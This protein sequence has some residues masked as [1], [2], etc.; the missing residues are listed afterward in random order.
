MW[1]RSSSSSGTVSLQGLLN[2][3][4][5]AALCDAALRELPS[6]FHVTQVW[7][8]LPEMRRMRPDQADQPIAK[9]EGCFLTYRALNGSRAK[10]KGSRGAIERLQTATLSMSNC[11]HQVRTTTLQ[12][13]VWTPSLSRST[14]G[15]TGKA[16]GSQLLSNRAREGCDV[17]NK[18]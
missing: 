10:V 9:Q 6:G 15:G 18:A 8:L 14:E 16:S 5:P 7:S 1:R 3:R 12:F 17:S 4:P 13:D 2:S 11:Q